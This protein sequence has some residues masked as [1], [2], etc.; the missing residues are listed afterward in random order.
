ML[1][2]RTAPVRLRRLEPA[3][4][5]GA[6]PAPSAATVTPQG[7]PRAR[8]VPPPITLDG[9]R[10]IDGSKAALVARIHAA[11]RR[12]G[13][14][15]AI[16]EAIARVE[17]NLDPTARSPDG[18]SVGAFQMKAPTAAAMRARL[19]NNAAG[20]PLGDEVTLGIGYLRYLDRLFSRRAVLDA[21]GH[22]TTPV[23]DARERLRFGIA[24]YNA[25]EGRVAAAQRQALAAGRD[26]RRF[27]HVH[28]YLPPITQRYV[29]KVLGAAAAARVGEQARPTVGQEAGASGL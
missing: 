3:A 2:Q 29:H 9:L 10:P 14:D 28:P 1:P 4:V 19:A 13:V 6:T 20:L 22:T 5:L 17:S 25:G 7:S 23:E 24:A 8:A 27:D 26:P 16:G 15:P 12:L 21:A 18:K 11:A